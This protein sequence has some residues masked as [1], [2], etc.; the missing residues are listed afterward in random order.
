MNRK[1]FAVIFGV[2]LLI[3]LAFV[4]WQGLNI[5]EPKADWLKVE[6]HRSVRA[7][8]M[9]PIRVQLLPQTNPGKLLVDLHWS[10]TR[11]LSEGFLSKGG[12]KSVGLQGGSF[13]FFI[14]VIPKDG[15]R[16]VRAVVFLSP[17]GSWQDHKLAASTELIPVNSFAPQNKIFLMETLKVKPSTVFIKKTHPHPRVFPRILTAF[18]FFCAAI[19]LLQGQYSTRGK[20]KH[21]TT[22]TIALLMACLWELFDLE[23]VL[24]DKVRAL[25]KAQD[26][27]HSREVLQ[28]AIVSMVTA[29]TSG[30][31]IWILMFRQSCKFL[32]ICL[33][34]YMGLDLVNL[35]SLHMIDSIAMLSW[36]GFTFIQLLKMICA[37]LI[38]IGVHRA[39]KKRMVTHNR[40]GLINPGQ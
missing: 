30:F 33:A 37:I 11:D 9:L 7:G 36:Q 20:F 16:F 2:L 3:T 38:L 13:D 4:V 6:S 34:C 29:A 12:V 19:R 5:F 31:F 17:N 40:D 23:T 39:I 28:K 14:P 35:V 15:I 26:L 21:G 27:Y 25:A 10:K 18:L 24:A 8:E 1:L 22:L 32:L